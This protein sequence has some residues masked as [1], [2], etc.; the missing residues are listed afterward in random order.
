MVSSEHGD[1]FLATFNEVCFHLFFV[2]MVLEREC[3]K[4]A[5]ALSPT[6]FYNSKMDRRLPKHMAIVIQIPTFH[7]VVLQPIACLSLFTVIVHN[8][9]WFLSTKASRVDHGVWLEEC[10]KQI[11]RDFTIL[12]KGEKALRRGL[13][14]GFDEVDQ[15]VQVLKASGIM[16]G[17]RICVALIQLQ[18]VEVI[19]QQVSFNLGSSQ[20]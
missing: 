14:G 10:P 13:V 12:Q 3:V 18:F 9:P 5:D 1:E 8:A 20:R 11:V 17:A 4:C 19:V 7:L 6:E 16:D 2:R 15:E